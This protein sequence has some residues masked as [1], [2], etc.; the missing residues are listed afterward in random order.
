MVIIKAEIDEDLKRKL[1][2]K[3]FKKFGYSKG[4]LS[5]A[6]R[7]AIE[8][9]VQEEFKQTDEFAMEMERLRNLNNA[10]FEKIESELIEKYPGMYGAIAKGKLL[11]IAKS[12]HEII[13]IANEK[14]PNEPHRLIFKIPDKTK[15]H[16]K[17]GK[18]GWRSSVV[19]IVGTT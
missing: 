17:R 18:L 1:W 15:K 14:A 3:A 10:F 9:W 16:K 11:G 4:A 7:E 19:K 2:E 5:K 13:K 6:I 8:K 12:F